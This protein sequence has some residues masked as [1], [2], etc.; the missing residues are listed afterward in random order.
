MYS[1]LSRAVSPLLLLF[2]HCLCSFPIVSAVSNCPPSFVSHC[3]CSFQFSLL[4]PTV[5]AVSAVFPLSL[6]VFPLSS[7]DF[8]NCVCSP[9]PSAFFLCLL[10]LPTVFY[11]FPTVSYYFPHCLLPFPTVSYNFPLFP[12]RTDNTSKFLEKN[13]GYLACSFH[14][15]RFSSWHL[16]R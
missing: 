9:L 7:S 14:K 15:I 12:G 8:L 5:S 4:F 16:H 10:L 6:A 1:S 11:Y 3:L 13:S 2:P